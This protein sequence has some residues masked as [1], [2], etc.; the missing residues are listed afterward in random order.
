MAL[1]PPD[2]EEWR[3]IPGYERYEVSNLG[4]VRS[5]YYNGGLR[6]VP[7][8]L[9]QNP[10][11][12]GYPCV[13]LGQNCTK[14]VHALVALAFVGPRP[15]GQECRHKN[16]DKTD[17]RLSNLH[18]GTRSQNI[19]DAVAHGTWHSAKR[20]A[21]WARTGEIKAAWWRNRAP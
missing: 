15:P 21:G 1:D 11:T 16:G 7:R 4:R 14:Q 18:Y 19:K 6:R 12:G 13:Q 5:L 10:N 17:A 2:T 8:V 20:Q 9:R 3:L